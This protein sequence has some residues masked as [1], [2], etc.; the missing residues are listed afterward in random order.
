MRLFSRHFPSTP[1][2]GEDI[3]KAS[4]IIFPANFSL[5]QVNYQ[6]K[7]QNVKYK[8][9]IDKKAYQKANYPRKGFHE[10]PFC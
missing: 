4:L 8:P 7:R 3:K 6:A 1:K 9:S 10:N 2:K 5:I